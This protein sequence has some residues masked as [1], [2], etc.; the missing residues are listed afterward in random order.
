MF[1]SD[2]L[3]SFIIDF[4]ILNLFPTEICFLLFVFFLTV[5]D[6]LSKFNRFQIAA[7]YNM[8]TLYK[9][10]LVFY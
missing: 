9:C 5:S 8:E 6:A 4:W 1:D 2:L 10:A 7:T 3:S